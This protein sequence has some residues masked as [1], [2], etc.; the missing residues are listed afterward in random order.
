VKITVRDSSTGTV[1]HTESVSIDRGGVYVEHPGDENIGVIP[2]QAHWSER[3]LTIPLA[4]SDVEI[5]F[6]SLTDTGPFEGA[7]GIDTGPTLDNVRLVPSAESLSTDFE[8][9][10]AKRIEISTTA[11][12]LYQLYK[13]SPTSNWVPLGDVIMG[14]GETFYLYDHTPEATYTVDVGSPID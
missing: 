12:I 6:E 11:G 5:T 8:L 2:L 1:F 3:V 9:K 4:S 10:P 14:T 7:P 13:R